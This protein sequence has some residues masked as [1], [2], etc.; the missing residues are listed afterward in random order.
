M[1]WL[2]AVAMF[3][4]LVSGAAATSI[5]PSQTEPPA[6]FVLFDAGSTEIS[7]AAQP[8]LAQVL[9]E[10]RAL[11]PTVIHVNGHCY[12]PGL[13]REEADRL[14]RRMAESVRDYIVA[15]GV[16]PS[17]IMLRWFVDDRPIALADDKLAQGLNRS[18]DILFD[19]AKNV[20]RP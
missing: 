1:R 6:F 9:A 16:P 12:D 11:E 14:S 7:P 17:A 15:Q 10:Y 3:V 19:D 20:L 13:A 18:V 4:G 5:T 8:V 2:V